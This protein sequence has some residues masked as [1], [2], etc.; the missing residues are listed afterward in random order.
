MQ[1][2]DFTDDGL[3]EGIYKDI[4]RNAQATQSWLESRGVMRD[5]PDWSKAFDGLEDKVRSE[6]RRI[7]KEEA[8]AAGRPDAYASYRASAYLN[9]FP[10][11]S[12]DD[13]S[14]NKR[15]AVQAEMSDLVGGTYRVIEGSVQSA[16]GGAAS[17][18]FDQSR[19]ALDE[20]YPSKTELDQFD[21]INIQR[22]EAQRLRDAERR[23]QQR[24]RN[25]ASRNFVDP[26]RGKPWTM[27]DVKYKDDAA[28]DAA[29]PMPEIPAEL[30]RKID[31]MNEP[32]RFG[33]NKEFREGVQRSVMGA[34]RTAVMTSPTVSGGLVGAVSQFEEPFDPMNRNLKSDVL[35]DSSGVGKFAGTVAGTVAVSAPAMVNP[36]WLATFAPMGY[37]SG[38]ARLEQRYEEAKQRA[39]MEGREAPK[40]PTPSQQRSAGRTGAVSETLSEGIGNA[41]ELAILASKGSRAANM[42]QRGGKHAAAVGADT[43]GRLSRNLLEGLSSPLGT[44]GVVSAVKATGTIGKVGAV[45]TIEEI[46]NIAAQTAMIDTVYDDASLARF[47]NESIEVAPVAFAAGGVTGVGA[48]AAQKAK[49]KGED[50]QIGR[51]KAAAIVTRVLDQI[52]DK[53]ALQRLSGMSQPALGVSMAQQQLED[54]R[55]GRRMAV[56]VDARHSDV[57]L[58]DEVKADM[59]AAGINV[60]N[61]VR[62]GNLLYYTAD[63]M[64]N[65]VMEAAK[66]GNTQFITGLPN[67]VGPNEAV[68]GA[69][70]LR[71][72]GGQIVEIVPYGIGANKDAVNTALEARANM[73]GLTVGEV[74]SQDAKYLSDT[75]NAQLDIDRVNAGGKPRTSN[76]ATRPDVL[77]SVQNL[78]GDIQAHVMRAL[79]EKHQQQQQQAQA[80]AEANGET[81]TP[82]PFSGK[83][84]VNL[85]PVSAKNLSEGERQLANAG[86]PATILDG[87][88]EITENGETRVVDI[89]M[90]GVYSGQTSADGV[91]LIRENGDAMTFR[92]AFVAAT[93]EGMHRGIYR[94]RGGAHW[95]NLLFNMDPVFSLRAGAAYWRRYNPMVANASD[96]E[97]INDMIA[98]YEAAQRVLGD[99]TQTAEARQQAQGEMAVVERFAEETVAE[100]A[101]QTMGTTTALASEHENAYRQTEGAQSRKFLA[102]LS[103]AL[104]KRGFFGKHAKAVL[105]M[106]GQRARGVREANL[107]LDA[108]YRKSAMA[109]YEKNMREAAEYEAQLRQ[110]GVQE[111]DAVTAASAQAA[112]ATASM[113]GA[114]KQAAMAGKAAIPPDEEEKKDQGEAGGTLPAIVPTA[115]SALQALAGVSAQIIPSGSMRP[116]PRPRAQQGTAVP[117][118]ET[119]PVEQPAAPQEPMAM[120]STRRDLRGEWWMTQDGPQFADGDFGDMN[121][122]MIAANEAVY[123]FRNYLLRKA[124][125]SKSKAFK[126]RAAEFDKFVDEGNGDGFDPSRVREEALKAIGKDIDAVAAWSEKESAKQSEDQRAQFKLMIDSVTGQLRDNRDYGL[127]KGWVRVLGNNLQFPSLSDEALRRVAD[128]LYETEGET[129]WRQSFTVEDTAGRRMFDDVPFEALEKGVAGLAPYRGARFSLRPI[130]QQEMTPAMRVWSM[131]SRFVNQNGEL[132]PLLHGTNRDFDKFRP[133]GDGTFGY[134]IYLTEDAETSNIY[135]GAS[136]EDMSS[137]EAFRYAAGGRNVPVVANARNPL[138]L[139]AAVRDNPNVEALYEQALQY[140]RENGES[141]LERI[142]PN[143]SDLV[144]NV[145]STSSKQD[146]LRGLGY[147]GII[148]RREDGSIREAVVFSP[149]QVKGYFNAN[150]TA[151][152]RMMFSMREQQPPSQVD[153]RLNPQRG[154][155]EGNP[156]FTVGNLDPTDTR[157]VDNPFRSRFGDLKQELRDAVAAKKPI[158]GVTKNIQTTDEWAQWMA[159][160]GLPKDQARFLMP[161]LFKNPLGFE[162]APVASPSAPKLTALQFLAEM[163]AAIPIESI[164][165]DLGDAFS[166]YRG[167]AFKEKN[168]DYAEVGIKLNYGDITSPIPFNQMTG[169]V[170]T[171]EAAELA[172][173]PTIFGPAQ[174][175]ITEQRASERQERVARTDPQYIES[176]PLVHFNAP[177]IVGHY[178]LSFPNMDK[179]IPQGAVIEDGIPDPSRNVVIEEVQ[180][181][182]HNEMATR[183]IAADR[184]SEFNYIGRAMEFAAFDTSI[185]NT[186]STIHADEA[187][188]ALGT[189]SLLSGADHKSSMDAKYRMNA[190][191]AAAQM[192][193]EAV[194]RAGGSLDSMFN[195]SAL[196]DFM[197]SKLNTWDIELESTDQIAYEPAQLKADTFNQAMPAAKAFAE[198][199][200]S[201]I[202]LLSQANAIS[203]L[204]DGT[205]DGIGDLTTDQANA[206]QEAFD[207]AA[208][209]LNPVAP[210]DFQ[211]GKLEQDLTTNLRREAAATNRMEPQRDVSISYPILNIAINSLSEKERKAMADAVKLARKY[212]RD[213]QWNYRNT[214]LDLDNPFID[215]R[216]VVKKLALEFDAVDAVLYSRFDEA[217]DFQDYD[218]LN[219]VSRAIESAA[220]S[221][222]RNYINSRKSQVRLSSNRANF[223]SLVLMAIAE[224]SVDGRITSPRFTVTDVGEAK[225]LMLEYGLIRGKGAIDVQVGSNRTPKE[226][227]QQNQIGAARSAFHSQASAFAENFAR[228][229]KN[230]AKAHFNTV[231][232]ARDGNGQVPFG[233]SAWNYIFGAPNG[234]NR[235]KTTLGMVLDKE[236]GG[237]KPYAAPLASTYKDQRLVPTN[238]WMYAVLSSAVME[239]VANG[240]QA[241]NRIAFTRPEETP[242]AA[243]MDSDKAASLYGWDVVETMEHLKTVNNAKKKA[244]LDP[245]IERRKAAIAAKKANEKGML[246]SYAESF[247][248]DFDAPVVYETYQIPRKPED[249]QLQPVE[250]IRPYGDMPR[251]QVILSDRLIEAAKSGQLYP[252]FSMRRGLVGLTDAIRQRFTDER[253][254]LRRYTEQDRQRRSGNMPDALNPYQ[255]SRVMSARIGAQVGRLER[256]YGSLIYRMNQQGIDTGM[257]DQFLTAQHARERN[258]YIASIN[259]AMPDGGSGMTNADAD[260][261]L[262]NHRAG[263]TFGIMDA[264]ATEWREILRDGLLDRLVSGIITQATYDRLTSTYQH[265]VP[266]RGRPA[267]PFD[268]DF[269]GQTAFGRGLS[270]Q[271]RGMPR[272]LGRQSR[273]EAVTSQVGFVAEDTVR[274]VERNRVANRFLRLVLATNDVGMAQVIRPSRRVNVD[275]EVRPV[276]D[277]DWMSGEAGKRNFGLFLDADMMIDGEQYRQGDLVVIQ[278]NN[279]RLADGMIA[280]QDLTGLMDVFNAP[281]NLFRSMTTGLLAPA[282]A[283]KNLIRDLYTG[284]LQNYARN[285]ILDTTAQTVRW[286]PSFFRI[287]VDEWRGTGPTGSYER[288]VD[289]GGDMSF[290][291]GNDLTEKVEQF[292][293]IERSVRNR[294]PDATSMIR[295]TVGWYPSLFKAA[296]TA[297]RLAHFNQ[298]VSRFA[299]GGPMTDEQA[300][301]SARDVTV[302]FGKKGAWMRV[303]NRT[304][305]Y[306]NAS[307]QGST[308]TLKALGAAKE[309]APTLVA[310]GFM[311]SL[312]ARLNAGD[313]EETGMNRWDMESPYDKAAYLYLYD[314]RQNGNYVRSP[315]AYGFNVFTT[316]GSDIADAV[317]GNRTTAGD[318]VANFVDNSLN[319]L[320][321][322]GGSGVTKGM[323]NMVSFA[324]PTLMRWFPELA[325]NSDFAGRA[326][327]PEQPFGPETTQAFKAFENTPEIYRQLAEGLAEM[328]GANEID[329]PA[330]SAMDIHP[331]TL[332]YMV[333]FM[334]SGFGRTLQRLHGIS[335][336]EMESR[337]FPIRR[338]FMGTSADN[339]KFVVSEYNKIKGEAGV[340]QA[341]LQAMRSP[342]AAQRNLGELDLDVAE[343]GTQIR[344]TDRA[345]RNLRD[346]IR[347]AQTPEE[348]EQ[349]REMRMQLMR[350]VIRRRNE[351]RNLTSPQ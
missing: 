200:L 263:G 346:A 66:T 299:R 132:V 337:D 178:R 257:M 19:S 193:E 291:R 55:S 314:P 309:L 40:P 85:K 288:F 122:E 141:R 89:P 63:A 133:S 185:S 41:F 300:A 222:A 120:F 38:Q 105:D 149:N 28:I 34:Y 245:A 119:A 289:A 155:Q 220:R 92:S 225:V 24:I 23:Q 317:F 341:R 284:T 106:F 221:V 136:L 344:A 124:E 169:T 16:I 347:S 160:R 107:T 99:T 339:D 328:G 65:D 101:T 268:E 322:F 102:W 192:F 330:L 32:E 61:P 301:L 161:W 318:V 266:L 30:Q 78:K 206:L 208:S 150:P 168:R 109:Q 151:D 153:I 29:Y 86:N 273:A 340:E 104:H 70:V 323:E 239:A 343:E 94:S 295:Y 88:V 37:E 130:S 79:M 276:F 6:R 298:R 280:A 83:V 76:V 53:N 191:G 306:M 111:G 52:T 214:T 209:E 42:V 251:M 17:F 22:Q 227:V 148:D 112:G 243:Y 248:S 275:G 128:Q 305:L 302:D 156:R 345:M 194:E 134:G 244:R 246:R 73:S 162:T 81:F 294:N 260:L 262:A 103:N 186:V 223:G 238:D 211:F 146:F 117:Q 176:G 26:V 304:H 213:V 281:N 310:I 95:M 190:A 46:G 242:S 15:G 203:E 313:D 114:D 31:Y 56:I 247:F 296:E 87:S 25:L 335:T 254:E 57:T 196:S 166:E 236:I 69:F 135:T 207:I 152:Q 115:V 240:A 145:I 198:R 215:T 12:F 84:K 348:K 255:G 287:L 77:A 329:P 144:M 3:F 123:D 173:R 62:Q 27:E 230:I 202:P 43:T 51:T 138:E 338:D 218:T 264:Y 290:A 277:Y 334:F 121:H 67:Y 325:F 129:V 229:I 285:G 172:S 199:L 171:T 321:A 159:T 139:N 125:K 126:I 80:E 2:N 8:I 226:L 13:W 36:A 164:T 197:R 35:Q 137:D 297:T 237:A 327:H 181:I 204:V 241:G 188:A 316:L 235:E 118:A 59:D 18:V 231:D 44:R 308:N 64:A 165:A 303:L 142:Y 278:I 90:D 195:E 232:L 331:D 20:N 98:R 163:D 210:D 97:V 228:D 320:N 350:D 72:A 201:E 100:T 182:L 21:I 189:P 324:F 258:A 131:G 147:D 58:S 74:S 282:F 158:V 54:Y 110:Q 82:T 332:E 179:Q 1:N 96:A 167:D 351:R 108:Q 319:Y 187:K 336:G 326:I 205:P 349:L 9:D 267:E 49:R 184:L 154:A 253:I 177:N 183:G 170:G 293:A 39:S 250:P 279:R 45:E 7:L 270:T 175:S 233:N 265:Y 174:S 224:R 113:R 259:P 271:G 143:R 14:K 127:A 93:H 252:M 311:Q 312:I 33:E 157:G 5:S 342:D 48:M 274:R 286:V 307:I 216:G 140:A 256:R 71:N 269:E 50:I 261:L 75:I 234:P 10:V 272:A 91:F 217:R 60:K 11:M 4:D 315:Q 180:S 333:G 116:Q 68:A 249:G 47:W 219:G 292:E 212:D 283:T